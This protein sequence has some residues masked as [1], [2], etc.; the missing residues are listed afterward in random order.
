M[1]SIFPFKSIEN[2]HDVYN[3]KDSTKKFCEFKR[4]SNED[5]IFQKKKNEV[6]SKQTTEIIWYIWPCSKEKKKSKKITAQGLA[7]QASLKKAK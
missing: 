4:A 6:I 7:W 2:E 1:S 5:N 3:G